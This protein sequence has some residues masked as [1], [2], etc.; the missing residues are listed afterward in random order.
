MGEVDGP[1]Y[2][3]TFAGAL[4]FSVTVITTIGKTSTKRACK[5]IRNSRF[6]KTSTGKAYE[7]YYLNYLNTYSTIA[8]NTTA[9]TIATIDTI[10]TI[11]TIVTI[12]TIAKQV[13]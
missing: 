11:Y 3:W 6:T 4:L 5:D 2:Q 12:H 13:Y 1:G 10:S 9:N 7:T 8:A